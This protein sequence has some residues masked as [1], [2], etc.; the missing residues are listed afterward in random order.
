MSKQEQFERC[1]PSI[2]KFIIWCDETN[3]SSS[4]PDS[5]LLYKSLKQ[6][7]LVG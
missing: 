4:N 2:K 3:R 6:A 1:H 5:L 7:G